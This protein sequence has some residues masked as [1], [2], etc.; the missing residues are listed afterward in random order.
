[1]LIF[2]PLDFTFV[3]PT[4]LLMFNE[5]QAEFQE[6][7]YEFQ[8]KCLPIFLWSQLNA[9]VLGI[10]VDSKYSHLAWVNTPRQ[11]GGLASDM[12][13]TMPLLADLTHSISRAYGLLNEQEGYS[14]R[15]LVIISDKGIVR[16]I[17]TNDDPVGRN[18]GEILRL[19]KAFGHTDTHP[20]EVCPIDWNGTNAILVSFGN[21]VN[22]LDQVG[23]PSKRRQRRANDSLRPMKWMWRS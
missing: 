13:F 16:D 14:N 5:K 11:N 1:V 22:V 15:G 17:V 2:Y 10:S 9:V 7:Q 8:F 4:E 23:R 6:V 21:L 19:L 18:C 20:G 3:C 12:P